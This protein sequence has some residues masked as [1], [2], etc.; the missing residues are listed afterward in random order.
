MSASWQASIRSCGA[1]ALAV[2]L[3]AGTA[4]AQARGAGPGLGPGAGPGAGQVRG[5]GPGAGPFAGDGRGGTGA[6]LEDSLSGPGP[7]ELLLG[8]RD[9]LG[10]SEAQVRDLEDIAES[11]RRQNAPLIRALLER[12]RQLQP[13]IGMRP[14]DMAPAQRAL[15]A[16]HAERARPIMQQVQRNNARAM[17]RVGQVLTAPQ[18]QQLR[19]WLQQSGMDRAAPGAQQRLR[20]RGPGGLDGAGGAGR[21]DGASPS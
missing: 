10:L 16:R 21:P 9:A 11:L 1:A 13:L 14:R 17:N 5:F 15:F 7:I 3:I 19:T 12:R 6:M 2:L 4:S 20:K 8:R 18:K